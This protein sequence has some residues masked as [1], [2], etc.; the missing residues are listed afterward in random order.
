MVIATAKQDISQ[1]NFREA[2]YWLDKTVDQLL[3]EAI[4]R[5]PDKISIVADRADREQALRVEHQDTRARLFR[6]RASA[7]HALTNGPRHAAAA[8]ARAVDDDALID[9]LLAAKSTGVD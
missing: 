6:G 9:Q 1:N 3:S 7:D 4:A 8:R 5:T 2:G